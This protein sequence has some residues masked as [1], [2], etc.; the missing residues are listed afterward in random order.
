ML[1]TMLWTMRYLPL[2]WAATITVFADAKVCA[3]EPTVSPSAISPT[4]PLP[5][6]VTAAPATPAPNTTSP[7]TA[8][9]N[10]EVSTPPATTDSAWQQSF[11]AERRRQLG[12]G[13]ASRTLILWP[14]LTIWRGEVVLVPG[15]GNAV[16]YQGPLLALAER[17]A[18]TGWR[19]WLLA[20]AAGTTQSPPDGSAASPNSTSLA[21]SLA[22][23][24]WPSLSTALQPTELTALQT[25]ISAEPAPTDATA[26]RKGKLPR[27]LLAQADAAALAW[28]EAGSEKTDFTGLV[29]LGAQQLADHAP[30][31]PVLE[32]QLAAQARYVAAAAQARQQRW[33]HLSQ[34]H[35]QTL[36]TSLRRPTTPWLGNVVDGWLRKIS[37]QSLM[38]VDNTLKKK[39]TGQ[40][41]NEM[42][43][44]M[45]GQS[46]EKPKQ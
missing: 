42:R 25:L 28:T 6:P 22:T 46:N 33:Q 10:T 38:P 4:T 39:L 9:P 30:K 37:K 13:A 26:E 34:Y 15:A 16:H 27:F 3:A 29:L 31:K 18:R 24:V 21:T 17:L 5:T 12:A 23:S 19:C 8:S 44:I 11:P 45:T 32:L 40:E 41:D 43:R 14:P 20:A 36:L 1:G 7:G 2:L 35:Q